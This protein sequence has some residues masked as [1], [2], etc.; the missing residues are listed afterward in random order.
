MDIGIN[1]AKNEYCKSV[2]VTG[3]VGFVGSHI[4]EA[5]LREGVKVVVYDIFNNETTVSAEKL[6][7]AEILRDTAAE[8]AHLG[9]SVTIVHGDI[10]DKPKLLGKQ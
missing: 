7:N 10:R 5:L 3:G 2:L 6:D 4:A 8:F 1:F 9:A